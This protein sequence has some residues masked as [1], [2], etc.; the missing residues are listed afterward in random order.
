MGILTL[1]ACEKKT[2]VDTP[3]EQNGMIQKENIQVDSN[4]PANADQDLPQKVKTFLEK[5]YPNIGIAKYEMKAKASGKEY[6]VKLNNGVEIEFDSTENWK[7][8]KDY[9]GVPDVFVPAKIKSYVTKNYP[10]IKI[11]KIDLKADKNQIKVELLNDTDLKFDMD[12]N[13]LKID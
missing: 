1:T 11:E 12:G 6:E 9:N 4:V 13:F 7:E 2:V 10:N 8:I 3:V 5:H